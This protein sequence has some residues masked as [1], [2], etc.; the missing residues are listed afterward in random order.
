MS[1][2]LDA[3]NKADQ[4]RKRHENLPGIGSN[5][6][7]FL[8]ESS[9]SIS[10]A[11]VIVGALLLICISALATFW[12]FK[13][14]ESTVSTNKNIMPMHAPQLQTTTASGSEMVVEEKKISI[15]NRNNE[16]PS[17]ADSDE[18]K[19][20]DLYQQQNNQTAQ[21]VSTPIVEPTV[22]SAP[23]ASSQPAISA[24]TSPTSI[25]QFANL[26]EIHDLPNNILS[27]IPTLNYSEHNYTINSGSVK[28]NGRI[29]HINEAIANGLVIDKIL[30]DGMI[31]H[32]ENYSFKM[33][34]LNS[35][36]NM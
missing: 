16:M 31:L 30:E 19:V 33:R 12:L 32:I 3:L 29:Y 23:I 15:D 10:P 17:I 7:N 5:H 9:R 27:Q 2:L 13:K 4:E 21:T 14:P 35:W 26:P 1:L 28:I 36:I 24:S 22:S 25:N 34:A 8:D 20:A 18:P 6:E 11:M